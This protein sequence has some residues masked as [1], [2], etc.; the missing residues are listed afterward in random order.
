M[1]IQVFLTRQHYEVMPEQQEMPPVEGNENC[2][3]G[4][5]RSG[6]HGIGET[7]SMRLG[8]LV[9]V[10]PC[11]LGDGLVNLNNQECLQELIERPLFLDSSD[12]GIELGDCNARDE[13]VPL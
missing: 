7:G 2:V 13:E 11:L 4:L 10:Q 1:C 12:P 8:E 6:D 5:C 9:P 3:T